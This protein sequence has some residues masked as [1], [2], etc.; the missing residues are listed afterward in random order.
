M[1]LAASSSARDATWKAQESSPDG[2]CD[3][4]TADLKPEHT[5]PPDQVVGDRGAHRPGTIGT[6]TPRRAVRKSRS[7]L[8]VSDSELDDSMTPVIRVQEDG[9]AHTVGDKGVVAEAR[10][11]HR[12]GIGELCPAHDQAVPVAVA[13]LGHPR[14]A[15]IGVLDRG[16]GCLVDCLDGPFDRFGL[17]SGDRVGDTV[18]PAGLY[19]MT[20]VKA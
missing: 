11:E 15:G 2:L 1:E 12:L 18:V 13:G 4:G 20:G 8:Q 7:F 17:P 9:V 14:L 19:D 5:E 6:K 16:P 10:E 3:K